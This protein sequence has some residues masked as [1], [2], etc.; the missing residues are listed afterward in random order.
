[1]ALEASPHVKQ[2]ELDDSEKPMPEV[3]TY[4]VVLSRDNP[5]VYLYRY[6]FTRSLLPSCAHVCTTGPLTLPLDSIWRYCPLSSS[7]AAGAK[8]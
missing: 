4:F 1:M 2:E 3:D 7:A 8:H 6:S 5:G